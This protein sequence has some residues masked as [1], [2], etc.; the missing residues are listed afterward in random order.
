MK[1]QYTKCDFRWEGTPYTFGIVREHEKNHLK[2]NKS[3]TSG[4]K[5]K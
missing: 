5:I 1:C 3:K 2:K 4:M